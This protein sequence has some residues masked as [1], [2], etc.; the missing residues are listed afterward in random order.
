MNPKRRIPLAS[1]ASDI[2]DTR[3]ISSTKTVTQPLSKKQNSKNAFSGPLHQKNESKSTSNSQI[4]HRNR[5]PYGGAVPSM[6]HA[7]GF[8]PNK[9]QYATFYGQ[10]PAQT[11]LS[12][13]YEYQIEP[14]MSVIGTSNIGSFA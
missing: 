10:K 12:G 8:M 7:P 9:Y 14:T 11:Q 5:D 2:S 3:T 6:T 4:D 13:G 1:T